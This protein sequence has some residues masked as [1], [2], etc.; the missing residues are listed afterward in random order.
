MPTP[1]TEQ[2]QIWCV[3]GMPYYVKFHLDRFIASLLRGEKTNLSV[4][5]TLCGG[6]NWRRKDKNEHGC[7]TTNPPLAND[8]KRALQ[9]NR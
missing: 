8:F 4:F 1:V 3:C 7:T 2:G 9:R 5:F 6:A